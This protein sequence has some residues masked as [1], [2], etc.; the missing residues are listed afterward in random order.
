MPAT[1]DIEDD[2][3]V[4]RRYGI[5]SVPVS[6]PVSMWMRSLPVCHSSGLSV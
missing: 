2:G 1:A 3:Y 5:S 4:V 6:T